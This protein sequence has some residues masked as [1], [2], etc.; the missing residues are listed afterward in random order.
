MKDRYQVRRAVL[1]EVI[2]APRAKDV[3]KEGQKWSKRPL[4]FTRYRSTGLNVID[5]V[6]GSTA[7][8]GY[9]GHAADARTLLRPQRGQR[10]DA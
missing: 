2:V 1:I 8:P 3:A 9:D 7:G 10:I 6:T 4:P 5:G